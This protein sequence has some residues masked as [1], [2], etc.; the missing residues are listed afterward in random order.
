LKLKKLFV[1][2]RTYGHLRPALLGRLKGVDLKMNTSH[3]SLYHF[4][5]I[6]YT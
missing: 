6:L 1:H 4:T 3:T 5:Y 2:A